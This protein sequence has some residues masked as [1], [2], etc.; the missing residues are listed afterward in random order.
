MCALMV[1]PS[2]L[3]I[4]LC[5]KDIKN[6]KT[7]PT[8]FCTDRD[9]WELCVLDSFG[10]NWSGDNG[11]W[12]Q[13]NSSGKIGYL[14]YF[15]VPMCQKR[16]DGWTSAMVTKTIR[17][18]MLEAIRDFVSGRSLRYGAT[19]LLHD[20]PHITEPELVARTGHA[21]EGN[22]K[23]YVISSRGMQFAAMRALAGYSAVRCVW[24]S[25][26]LVFSTARILYMHYYY[27][28]YLCIIYYWCP[29]FRCSFCCAISILPVF[30]NRL[31][32]F[33]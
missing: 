33:Y 24:L 25:L 9:H 7:K 18:D 1:L 32:L 19:T 28:H 10:D 4:S 31:L 16:S 5:R 15:A 17:N 20:H 11:L 22:T 13:C 8:S 14:Q 26:L 29:L 23:H 12:R 27:I 3:N 6:A 2:V 30:T 21:S